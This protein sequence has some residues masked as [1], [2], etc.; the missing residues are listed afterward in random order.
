M[1]G[2]IPQ[3]VNTKILRGIIMLNHKYNI[4]RNLALTDLSNPAYQAVLLEYA[5]KLAPP[6]VAEALMQRLN[7]K[8][9]GISSRENPQRT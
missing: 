9:P 5:Q 7:H 2:A 4:V 6:C 8:A 3:A 1:V